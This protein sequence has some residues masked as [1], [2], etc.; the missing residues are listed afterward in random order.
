MRTHAPGRRRARAA[1]RACSRGALP[2]G[3]TPS[4]CRRYATEQAPGGRDASETRGVRRRRP[5]GVWRM[6]DGEA[7]GEGAASII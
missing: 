2:T 4:S 5:P 6:V 1:R 7:E 3:A